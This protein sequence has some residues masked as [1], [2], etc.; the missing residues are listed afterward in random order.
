MPAVPSASLQ[1]TT[2]PVNGYGGSAT[3][4]RCHEAD[5]PALDVFSSCAGRARGGRRRSGR[6]CRRTRRKTIALPCRARSRRRSA[7]VNTSSPEP[8]VAIRS[9][10]LLS[11]PRNDWFSVFGNED[12]QPGEWG[13]W[14]SRGMSWN[15]MCAYCHNT[16]LTKGYDTKTD[17]YHTTMSE[18]GVGCEACHGPMKAHADRADRDP[19]DREDEPA[20]APRHVRLVPCA[21]RRAHGPLHA[22][23]S[24]RRSLRAGD[25]R[26]G[27]SVLRGRA[28][29]R[30]GLRADVVS[31]QPHAS[32]GCRPARIATIHTRASCSYPAMRSVCA[33]TT[34]TSPT[35]RRSKSSITPFTR[36]MV[37]AARAWAVTCRSPPTCKGIRAAITASPF[38]DPD[39][40]IAYAIPNACTRCHGDRPPRVGR[41]LGG[42]M[43]R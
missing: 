28:G 26:F 22:R 16:H 41:A 37:R 36:S 14:T 30:R 39:L 42:S 12:R 20:A 4:R 9:C 32:R 8:M 34:A 19:T 35:F 23:R 18:P 33:A 7:A 38:P 10:R 24:L 5:V 6:R 1:T 17:G 25:P 13:H 15:A 40:T 43:V 3:C 2:I 31:R 29:S 21:S 11:I 27:Q